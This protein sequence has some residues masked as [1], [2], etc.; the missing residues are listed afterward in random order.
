MMPECEDPLPKLKDLKKVLIQN[1]SI[2]LRGNMPKCFKAYG[3]NSEFFRLHNSVLL[4][5]G[6]GD[7]ASDSEAD[8]LNLKVLV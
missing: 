8:A 2:N 6:F 4:V 7:R 3:R 5:K 1:C